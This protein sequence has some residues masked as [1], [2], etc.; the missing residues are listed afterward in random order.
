MRTTVTCI[1]FTDELSPRIAAL[2]LQNGHRVVAD[3]YVSALQFDLLRKL[4]PPDVTAGIPYWLK[5]DRIELSPIV[6]V[7]LWFD[8]P[9]PCEPA[10]ALLD[11]STEWIFNKNRIF[12]HPD[13]RNAHLSMVISA[14]HRYS[15]MPKDELLAVVL[16]DVRA[17]IP[18]AAHANLVKSY[19]VRWPKATISPRPGVDSLRP[20]QRSPISNLY[21]A[22]EWT[23]TGWPS[24]MESAARSGYLVAEYILADEGR[25]QSVLVPDLPVSRLARL[26]MRRP[27]T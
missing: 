19:V 23:K 22:G 5:M 11:R 10:I 24:T 27:L 6:G 1:H 17:C 2:S 3:Y 25:P 7:N 26:L 15:A 20:D 16:K 18:L 12:G 14:S 21:V 8:R 9:I 4:I 13:G